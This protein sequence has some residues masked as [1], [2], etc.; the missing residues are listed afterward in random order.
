MTESQDWWPA[1]FG[2]YG[3]QFV[4]MAWHSSG[5][6]RTDDGRGGGGRGQQ[7]FA[8]SKVWINSAPIAVIFFWALSTRFFMLHASALC[9]SPMCF[10]CP[11]MPMP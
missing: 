11:S 3:P 7:R 9:P 5:T 1:D 8:P 10:R 2:H 4:R 6:Y